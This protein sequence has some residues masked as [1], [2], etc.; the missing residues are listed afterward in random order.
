MHSGCYFHYSQSVYRRIQTLGLATAYSNDQEIRS[1]CRKLIS[2][3][4]MPLDTVE[5][6]FYNLRA[7]LDSRVKQELRQL[8][9]YFDHYWM[10]E[11][12][13]E[14]WNFFGCQ[15]R[16]NNSCEGMLVLSL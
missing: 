7:G 10:N 12:P 16:T 9:L 2:L 6:S 3:A 1:C 11:M 15:H 8:F 14:M 4:L 5:T 13:L